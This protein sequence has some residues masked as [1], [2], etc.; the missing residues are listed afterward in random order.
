[1]FLFLVFHLCCSRNAKPSSPYCVSGLDANVMVF[2]VQYG[3]MLANY[4]KIKISLRGGEWM[5]LICTM[6]VVC[7]LGVGQSKKLPSVTLPS[8][9]NHVEV[10]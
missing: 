2:T 4:S 9:V 8:L 7:L 5:Q 3:R 6:M 1:M 10:L